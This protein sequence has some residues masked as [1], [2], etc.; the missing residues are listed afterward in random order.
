[1]SCRN[2]VIIGA[3]PAGLTA[4]YEL[5]RHGITGTILETDNVVGGI[6]RTVERNGYRFDVGGHRFFSKSEE[7]TMLWQEI[8]SEDM[9]LRPRLSR[10]YYGGKFYDYPLKA[11][12]ALRNMG[13]T[14]AIACMASYG[15]AKIKPV[16]DP[17]SLEAW[18]TNQFGHKLYSMFFKTYTEK[19]WG[20]SCSELGADWAAQRIKG[21]NLSEVV[22]N[23]LFGNKKGKVI[24]TLIDQFLYPR[25]GPG[26][27]WEEAACKVKS[28]GWQ[29]LTNAKVTGLKLDDGGISQITAEHNGEELTFPCTD[30]I[31]SMPLRAL[32]HAFS[33]EVPDQVQ[34]AADMLGYRD[35]VTVALVLDVPTLFPDNW[36]YIHSPEVK[37]GRIQNFKNW[38]PEMVPDTS[39]TC[40]GLEYFV[41]EGDA[42]WSAPDA[43]LVEL[44]YR[45]LSTIGLAGGNLTEG[46]VVR[47]PKA[48]PVYDTGYLKRLDTLKL[49]L[50][51]IKGLHCVG[52]NGQHRYNNM[53][54]S[55]MT[56]EES[57]DEQA[58]THCM[59]LRYPAAI[60]ADDV[61][62]GDENRPAWG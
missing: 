49:W 47:M 25:L 42:I 23:A 58:E 50:T 34:S 7:I 36:I 2:V 48:Y 24:K 53:D 9:L 33:G 32:V 27:L 28:K 1:M 56:M 55:M 21:L 19:V 62:P 45:E 38:S 10:I 5:S 30:V 8:L 26:Q 43:E 4:A 61:C 51:S 12:N 57:R 31:S 11:S 41:N 39:K 3:G 22:K 15:I 17:T 13:L 18:V 44:G 59:D 52:R 46:H 14:T 40:L 20:I 60:G 35:F 6:S 29:L 54:H 16:N 37:L